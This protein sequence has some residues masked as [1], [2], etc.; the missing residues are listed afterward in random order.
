MY[1]VEPGKR[2]EGR[3]ALVTGGGSDPADGDFGGIGSATAML[4]AKAGAAV[5]VFDLDE[6]AAR[7]TVS[8]IVAAGG[9]GVAV[10]GNIAD[11]AACERAIKSAIEAFGRLDI[12]VNNAAVTSRIQ[13]GQ[14]TDEEWNKVIGT[15]L[16]GAMTMSRLALP[17]LAANK[18]GSIINMVSAAAMRG[19]ATPAY[20][21][22]KG[23]LIALTV[24]MAGTEGPRGVRVN[25]IMPGH[26]YTPMVQRIDGSTKGRRMRANA[27][28]L[29][30]EGNSVDV[31]WAALFLAGDEARWITGVVLPVDAGM[32]VSAPLPMFAALNDATN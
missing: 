20:A 26:V 10:A 6:A 23:A 12:L 29:R 21:A 24:D 14:M 32:S 3:V 27:S 4:M 5:V 30:T 15:N 28:P 13:I 1:A 22:S 7:H 11:A 9:R 16:T 18:T 17:H 8:R 31:A 2:L 25:A 19:F